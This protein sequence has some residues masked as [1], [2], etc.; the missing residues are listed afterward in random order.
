M[1]I[2]L[3]PVSVEHSG[4]EPLCLR[5]AYANLA[6]N[7]RTFERCFQGQDYTQQVTPW[8]IIIQTRG[9]T[10]QANKATRKQ[11]TPHQSSWSISCKFT[12]L[13]VSIICVISGL[14]EACEYMSLR[15]AVKSLRACDTIHFFFKNHFHRIL[16]SIAGSFE[17][18]HF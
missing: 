8:P 16:K 4:Q 1:I 3:L 10:Y 12:C 13:Y 5:E 14:R 18:A 15:E 2:L 9:S 17:R 11:G 6:E 7:F